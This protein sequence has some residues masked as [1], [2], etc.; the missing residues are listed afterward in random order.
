MH[1]PE[2]ALAGSTR[3]DLEQFGIAFTDAWSGLEWRFLKLECWQAY[4][5]LEASESQTAYQQG[6]VRAAR[7]FLHQEA[8][9]DRPLYEDVERRNIEYARV[10][11]LQEPLSPYLEYELSSYRIRAGMG[12]NI[13]IVTCEPELRLPDE[14]HFDFLLFDRRTALIHDY[15][16]GQIGRQSGGWLT[17][18]PQV[19][20]GLE[21]I[22][23]TLRL[24]AVPLREYPGR[25]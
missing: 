3:L 14:E 13:E 7:D 15:G 12:E 23:A 9:A 6:D 11:L 16:T 21:E 4:Q 5:E 2:W 22:V 24:K 18:E 25:P 8:A 1:P 19:I 20:A 17:R 10:R